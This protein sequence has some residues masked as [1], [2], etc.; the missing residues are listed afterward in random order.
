MPT[1]GASSKVGTSAST[2]KKREE[3]PN[4]KIHD[5]RDITIE[6]R[7]KQQEES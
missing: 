2:T 7:R 4:L 1:A 6:R 3:D 5:E